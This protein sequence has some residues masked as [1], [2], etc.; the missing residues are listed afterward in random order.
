MATP[1]LSDTQ[2]RAD[3]FQQS[4]LANL[5]YWQDW[6]ETTGDQVVALDQHRAGIVKA[7]LFGLDLDEAWPA[8]RELIETCSSYME[9][10]GYWDSWGSIL[11]LALK[12]AGR[13]GDEAGLANLSALVA[14]LL[15]RQ[16][17]F[18]ESAAYYRRTMRL[19]RRSGDRFNQARAC[20]NLGYHYIEHGYWQRAEVLCCRALALFE[21]L[22]SDHGRAHTQNHLGLLYLR[23]GRWDR[24]RTYLEQAC[25]LWQALR[26]NHGLMYGF[27][28]LGSLYN[29]L[30]QPH[31]ALPYLQQARQLAV[32]SGEETEVALIDLSLGNTYRLSGR[33]FEA[34]AYAHRAEARFQRFSNFYNLPLAWNNLAGACLDQGK[35]QQ[36]AG[37]LQQA[38]ES[39]REMKHRHGEMLTLGSWVEYELA[40][41][42]LPAAKRRLEVFS[43]F[44]SR[45]R[46]L[47]KKYR[48][49]LAKD[50]S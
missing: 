39:C 48:R 7:I 18:Q 12:V 20:S 9:R 44:I 31:Q 49:S 27:L 34:E 16:G 24:A 32:I 23:Q 1:R 2:G 6:L 33:A 29:E 17:H 22:D 47:T 26:D 45:Q 42:D 50:E 36:A 5:G 28:N 21:Q 10:R 37:Y 3:F 4:L 13:Q 15:H 19:A 8:V 30:G 11:E 38:L 43:D 40:R 25:A 14:R 35:W 41:G 46:I